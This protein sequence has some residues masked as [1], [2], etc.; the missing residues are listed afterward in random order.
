[1]RVSLHLSGSGR[2]TSLE[3]YDVSL[4]K[5]IPGFAKIIILLQTVVILFL[6]FWIYQEYLNNS[7][8][9]AYLTGNLQGISFTGIVLIF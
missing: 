4:W 2:I 8:L 1:L 5:S 9:Q 6:S 7:Y 3:E